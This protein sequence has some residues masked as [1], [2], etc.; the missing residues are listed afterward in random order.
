MRQAGQNPHRWKVEQS[1]APGSVSVRYLQISMAAKK[2]SSDMAGR[3]G[4]GANDWHKTARFG[5]QKNHTPLSLLLKGGAASPALYISF[6]QYHPQLASNSLF[7]GLI[8]CAQSTAS[9]Q[10]AHT[11]PDDSLD[12][13]GA[14]PPPPS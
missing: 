6:I 11:L 13:Y 8:K 5:I 3:L 1:E 7:C 4:E 12:P 14:Q 2:L 10:K 9:S